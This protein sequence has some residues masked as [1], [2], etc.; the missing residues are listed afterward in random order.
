MGFTFQGAG[1]FLHWLTLGIL[2]VMPVL[3]GLG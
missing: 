1:S 3:I 2:F